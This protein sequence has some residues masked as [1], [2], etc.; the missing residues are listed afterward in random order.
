MNYYALI[1]LGILSRLLPHPP[2]VTPIAALGLFAGARGRS[3]AAWTVPL[4]SLLAT[5]FWLGGYDP[6][7]ML[8][9]Y[10][11]FAC[12]SGIGWLW[13][14]HHRSMT[15]ITAAAVAMSTAFFL[16]S[17]FGCWLSGMYPPTAE[18]L[19][20]CYLQGLPWFGASLLGDVFYSLAIIGIFDLLTERKGETAAHAA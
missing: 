6:I 15:R 12:S 14:R 20:E 8:F 7:A 1:A 2:N 17:N 13:L 4:L 3:R 19:I 11:G 16:L 10:F 5:D 18:G 9:V